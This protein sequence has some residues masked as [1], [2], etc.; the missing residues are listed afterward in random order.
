MY[1]QNAPQ[2]AW[3][4]KRVVTT[5]DKIEQAKIFYSEVEAQNFIS[6]CITTRKFK[7]EPKQSALKN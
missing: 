6:H 7:V 4:K 5:T 3:D 1:V 2:R